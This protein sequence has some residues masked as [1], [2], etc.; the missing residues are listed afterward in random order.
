MA[1]FLTSSPIIQDLVL[2]FVLIFTLVFAILERS[3]LLG[4]GKKQI[5]AIIAF[6]VAGVFLAFSEYVSWIKQFSIVLVVSLFIIFIF[7]LIWG[8]VW[9]DKEGDPLK[10]AKGLKWTIGIVFLIIIIIS[11]LKITG[12][13]DKL[14]ASSTMVS[15]IIFAVLIIA[16]VV[17]VVN[18]GKKEDKK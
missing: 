8:F 7:L 4:E 12:Y 18:S 17:A 11:A 15:N 2:P 6:V 10:E 13:I 1:N 9:G 3:K 16:A 5:N 14:N